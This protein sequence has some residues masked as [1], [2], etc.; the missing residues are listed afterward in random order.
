MDMGDEAVL[1]LARLFILISCLVIISFKLFIEHFNYLDPF[2]S[3][4]LGVRIGTLFDA[5]KLIVI[6]ENL[7]T[8]NTYSKYNSMIVKKKEGIT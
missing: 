5:I 8:S 7:G 6:S 2:T 1:T 4:F 3:T